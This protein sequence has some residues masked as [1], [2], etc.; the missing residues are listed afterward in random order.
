MKINPELVTRAITG[1]IKAETA[2]AGFK[3]V[4]LGLS[5]GLDST[6]CACLAVRALGHDKVLA[7]I[8]PYKNLDEAGVAHAEKVASLLKIK[9]RK[10]DISP[11]I[12]LYFEKYPTD[13][14]VL[15]GNKMARERMSI[16]YDFS[17]REKAL[18][19]GTSNKTELLI[20]YGTI[21]G[22]M[23]CGIN[24]MGDL[25]KTQVREL[26]RYLQIPEEILKKKPTAGLW[27]GQTDEEE[28]GL[29]YEELD[30]ILYR[31]VDLRQSAEE[32][33]RSG[34]EEKKVKRIVEMIKRSEFKR[35]MP[36]I[37]KISNRTVGH[38]F[39]YPYDWDK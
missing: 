37:V 28:I 6:V 24:P 1:F 2:R 12:D 7:L 18:I 15:K 3:K 33:I 8:M 10:I 9:S 13:S 26:G 35:R 21:H 34:F 32:I 23:A 16:L 38:D 36:P 27:P 4:V 29:S 11:Q 31:L 30:Q 19:L 25:Y 22:D 39:L 20:G 17:A 14:Q 5:G